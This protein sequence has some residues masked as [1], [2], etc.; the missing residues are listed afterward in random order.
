MNGFIKREI[1]K[2]DYASGE[3]SEKK[4]PDTDKKGFRNYENIF[5]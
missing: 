1:H 3:R 5:L 4:Y 2:L